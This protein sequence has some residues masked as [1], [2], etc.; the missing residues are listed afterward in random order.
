MS[1]LEANAT[2]RREIRVPRVLR[3]LVF[4]AWRSDIVKRAVCFPS[5]IKRIYR[6]VIDMKLDHFK[7]CRFVPVEIKIKLEELKATNARGPGTTVPYYVMDDG[8]Y[9][10]R[11]GEKDNDGN[12]IFV[13]KDDITNS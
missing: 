10:I 9:G 1:L 3:L 12:A 13:K 7:A 8:T 2:R 11:F 5:S 4:S 6:T